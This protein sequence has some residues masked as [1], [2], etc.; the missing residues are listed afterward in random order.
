MYK[1]TPPIHVLP[2]PPPVR[3]YLKQLADTAEP[4]SERYAHLAGNSSPQLRYQP[5]PQPHEDFSFLVSQ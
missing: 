3:I 4:P 1:Y 5:L 2:A